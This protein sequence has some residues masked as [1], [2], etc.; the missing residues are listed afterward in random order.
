MKS[1]CHVEESSSVTIRVR[2]RFRLGSLLAHLEK[3][4][5]VSLRDRA[6]DA[7]LHQLRIHTTI[8]LLYSTVSELRMY[9][10]IVSRS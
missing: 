6:L 9:M 5:C 3:R 10:I 7:P 4:L 1:V 8:S 2:D